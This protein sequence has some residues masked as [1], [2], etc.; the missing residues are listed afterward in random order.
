MS[1]SVSFF[2]DKGNNAERGE[3]GFGI[4][5]DS[6]WMTFVFG[7]DNMGIQRYRGYGVLMQ[8]MG[9]NRMIGNEL[10]HSVQSCAS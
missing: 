7:I 9:L 8:G 2:N 1:E 5:K 6:L 4:Q 3:R 10:N